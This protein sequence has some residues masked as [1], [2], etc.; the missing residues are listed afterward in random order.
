MCANVLTVMVDLIASS[1][2]QRTP[3]LL[4][5]ERIRKSPVD[6]FHGLQCVLELSWYCCY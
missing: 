1:Y 5:L 3:V 4:T 6:S 2:S